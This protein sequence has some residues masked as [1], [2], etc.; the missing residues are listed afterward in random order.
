MVPN[1]NDVENLPTRQGHPQITEGLYEKPAI[2]REFANVSLT[3]PEVIALIRYREDF[4]RRPVLDLGC[5][6]GRLTTYLRLLTDRYVGTDLSSAM[7][8]HCRASFPKLQFF[9]GDMRSLT[10]CADGSF[11]AVFA[12]FNVLDA[13]GH[14]DRLRTLAEIHR[15]LEAGGLLVF[16][17]HNRNCT[18]DLGPPRLRFSR[19]LFTQ[20]RYVGDYFQSRANHRRIKPLQRQEEDYALCND[21]GHNFAVL[22]YYITRATQAKQ[23]ATAGFQLLEC[24]DDLGRTLNPNDDDTA[25]ASLHYVARR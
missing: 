19:N 11:H 23:L 4:E 15:V 6:A 14:Q 25:V 7:V 5:G 1:V 24:L 10:K 21:T 9:Q 3:P 13:V 16:S 12:A 20:L 22:H 18:V 2:V 8:A 17:T